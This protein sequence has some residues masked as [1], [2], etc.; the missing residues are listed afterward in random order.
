VI[1]KGETSMKTVRNGFIACLLVACVAVTALAQVSPGTLKQI[2][3]PDQVETR[4]GALKFFDGL[5]DKATVEKLYDNLD[6]MRGVEVFLSLMPGA[7]M[8]AFGQGY[9]E[10]GSVDSTIGISETLTDS[11]ALLLTANTDTVYAGT[12]IDLKNGP[13][14]VESPPNVLGIVNDAWF[15]YV[16]DL[17]NAGPDRGKGGKYL[18]LPPG[19]KGE[20]PQGYYVFRSPTYG[21]ALM[22]RGFLVNGESNPAVENIKRHARVYPLAHVA[23][24]PEPKFINTSGLV[25]NTI[26][27]GDFAFFEQVNQVVQNEPAEALDTEFGGLLASIG[28]VKGKPFAPDARMKKILEDAAAVGNATARAISVQPRG[29]D[30]FYYPGSSWLNCFP[31]GSYEFL[32]DGHHDLD[33]RTMYFINAIFVTPAMSM[34][35]VG[36]GS[37]YAANTRDSQGRLLDGGK[38]YR[39]HLPPNVPAKDF[40]SVVVYDSQTRSMLQTSQPF[41][42]LNSY[43]KDLAK[44]ADG[45]VDIYFGP[46]PPT[47]KESNW[48]QTVS[49]KS[50]NTILRLYGP[51]QPWFDKTWRPGEIEELK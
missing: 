31:G 33:A 46:K 48:I 40:W 3:T 35:M 9:R 7:S 25:Y 11:K 16:A 38:A 51:L 20:V 43:G 2:S 12:W 4:L 24:P 28:I 34:K 19:Y 1:E 41:P 5:P 14:V 50:W 44:N 17:G 8:F 26:F 13:V 32:K 45:S 30:F 47:G 27:A 36:V 39:L 10:V 49:G 15:R 6:F 42:S 29:K 21:N 37:Q 22:W 23:N 18:F